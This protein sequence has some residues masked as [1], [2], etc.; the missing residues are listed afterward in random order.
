MNQEMRTACM[1]CKSTNKLGFKRMFAATAAAAVATVLKVAAINNWWDNPVFMA[2]AG[3]V[4]AGVSVM[5]LAPGGAVP[6]LIKRATSDPPI[7][8]SEQSA[9]PVEAD[10]VPSQRGAA[11]AQAHR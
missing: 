6:D 9:V 3:T 7:K 4:L 2:V 10:A 5:L 1:Y 8:G 11:A